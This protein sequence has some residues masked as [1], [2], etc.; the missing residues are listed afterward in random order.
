MEPT[1]VRA[2]YLHVMAFLGVVVIVFGVLGFALGVV[3]TADPE[4]KSGDPFTSIATSLVD[5]AGTVSSSANNNGAQV[6]PTVTNGISSA[7]NELHRQARNHSIDGMLRGLFMVLIGLGVYTY[8]MRKTDAG[9]PRTLLRFPAHNGAPPVAPPA[10][11]VQ[12]AAP[13]QWPPAQ[14]PPAYPA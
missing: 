1:W 8:H 6:S 10:P 7:K 14:A 12:P 9:R 2:V 3:H 4:L 11:P 13:T 5:I